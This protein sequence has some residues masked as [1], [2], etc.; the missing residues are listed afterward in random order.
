MHF[1]YTRYGADVTWQCDVSLGV[2]TAIEFQQ[3]ADLDRFAGIANEQ[4]ATR[5]DRSLVQAENA[6]PAFE[7]IDLDVK[8]VCDRVSVRVRA[9]DDFFGVVA[10]SLEEDGRVAF[11]RIGHQALEYLQQL[12]DPR[13]SLCRHET[14]GYQ[15]FFTQGLLEWFVQL[16]GL[17]VFALFEVKLHEVLI[18]LDDLVYDLRVCGF[19]IAKSCFGTF[20][21]KETVDDSDAFSGR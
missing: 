11:S 2:I 10:F 21:L 3:L 9:E 5:L 14:D 4:L 6:E 20:R 7:G 1:I 15:V 16:L 17:E 18:D 8:N 13:A 12:L 19:D